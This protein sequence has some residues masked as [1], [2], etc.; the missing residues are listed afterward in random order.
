MKNKKLVKVYTKVL[1][2]YVIDP[3][4][5]NNFTGKNKEVN[6]VFKITL[7]NVCGH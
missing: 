4:L 1:G 5:N 7:K 2:I 3:F 6:T